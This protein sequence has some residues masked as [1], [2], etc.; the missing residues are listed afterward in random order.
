[1][2][3]STPSGFSS[4]LGGIQ[5]NIDDD[6]NSNLSG[7]FQASEVKQAL[8]KMAPLTAPGPNGMSPVFYKTFWHIVGEDV[9]MVVLQALNSGIFPES[10]NTTFIFLIPKIKNPRKVSDFRL[11]SLCNVI[12]KLITKVVANHLKKF[13]ANSI[14][15]S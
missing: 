2:S 14:L 15:N 7:D 8:N 3:S 13:L 1:M 12:Y 11:I 9:T 5:R 4:I 6:L 10:I